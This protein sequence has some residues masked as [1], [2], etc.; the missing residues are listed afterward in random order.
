VINNDL[1]DSFAELI[2]QWEKARKSGAFPESLKPEL[3]DITKDFHLET[4]SDTEW[5]LFPVMY[6]VPAKTLNG[7]YQYPSGKR[8]TGKPIRIKSKIL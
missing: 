4:V 6:E 2:K 3:Q 1:D 5:D 8:T 7:F